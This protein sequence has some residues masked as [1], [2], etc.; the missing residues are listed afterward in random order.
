MA[1]PIIAA[2]APERNEF[3]IYSLIEVK[4]KA[5]LLHGAFCE[6]LKIDAKPYSAQA[7]LR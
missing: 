3:M 2:P 5:P 1:M 6:A 7:T 4:E